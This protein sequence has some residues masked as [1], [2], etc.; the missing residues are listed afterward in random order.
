MADPRLT[1][2]AKF[3]AG[4][5]LAFRQWSSPRPGWDHDHCAFCWVKLAGSE[6]PG[7][8]HEGYATPN[9]EHW[10]CASC[11]ADFRAMFQWQVA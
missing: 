2:Q 5:T 10:V 8:L 3:L 4:K 11:F 6:V 7:A 1:N 9:G